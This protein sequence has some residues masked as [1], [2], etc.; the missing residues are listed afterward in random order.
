MIWLS[1]GSSWKTQMTMVMFNFQYHKSIIKSESKCFGMNL[2]NMFCTLLKV[3]LLWMNLNIFCLNNVYNGAWWGFTWYSASKLLLIFRG[4]RSYQ[5]N[6]NFYK[7]QCF[8]NL[9]SKAYHDLVSVCPCETSISET[10]P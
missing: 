5:S 1:R 3:L 8:L 6:S 7:H 4:I 9:C 2:L 10:S